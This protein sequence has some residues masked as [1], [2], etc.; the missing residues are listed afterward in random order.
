MKKKN[1][2]RTT[3]LV[4][5]ILVTSRHTRAQQ[6]PPKDFDDYINKAL[7]YWDLPGLAITIVKSDQSFS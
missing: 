2:L 6:P 4:L 5:L 7:K 1:A 3:A